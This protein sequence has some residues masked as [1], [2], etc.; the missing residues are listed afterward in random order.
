MICIGLPP[1][2]SRK[3]VA[4]A[5]HSFA[6]FDIKIV[7]INSVNSKEENLFCEVWFRYWWIGMQKFVYA[8]A[9]VYIFKDSYI[10]KN[11]NGY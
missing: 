3:E 2:L 4:I 8:F 1:I 9:K 7:L 11:V 10:L 6:Y 5:V